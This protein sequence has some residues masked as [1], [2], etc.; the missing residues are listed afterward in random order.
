MSLPLAQ[1]TLIDLTKPNAL[2]ATR[3]SVNCALVGLL[4][5]LDL[6]EIE[7]YQVLFRNSAKVLQRDYP[8]YE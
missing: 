6:N 7:I 1:C 4:F 8:E 2:P 5:V 3:D